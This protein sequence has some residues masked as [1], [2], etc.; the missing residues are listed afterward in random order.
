MWMMGPLYIEMSFLCVI[1]DWLEGCGWT[2]T[3]GKPKINTLGR[4]QS[5][6]DEVKIKRSDCGHQI[7]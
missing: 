5:I 7:S 1:G 2:E 6:L 3:S 4:I